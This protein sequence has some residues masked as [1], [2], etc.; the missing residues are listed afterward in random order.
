[1]SEL[2]ELIF[3]TKISERVKCRSRVAADRKDSPIN[4][5]NA[6]TEAEADQEYR[7]RL[8]SFASF[9]KAYFTDVVQE[10][11]ETKECCSLSC[12]N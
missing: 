4:C 1:M 9:G 2:V 3:R 11:P 8:S 12:S 7:K 10:K 5:T 6:Y